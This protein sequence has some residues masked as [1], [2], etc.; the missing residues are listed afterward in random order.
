MRRIRVLKLLPILLV[1]L[2]GG[3]I[4]NVAVAW[5]CATQV[6]GIIGPNST[7]FLEDLQRELAWVDR[8]CFCIEQFA[9]TNEVTRFGMRSTTGTSQF[10][11]QIFQKHRGIG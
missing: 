10:T 5:G 4:I 8:G 11:L 3:A 7:V 1:L 6:K 9:D 2:V